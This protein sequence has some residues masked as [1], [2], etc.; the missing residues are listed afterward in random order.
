MKL[1][2]LSLLNFKNLI[3][4]IKKGISFICS[5]YSFLFVLSSLIS[6]F[7]S[8]LLMLSYFISLPLLLSLFSSFLPKEISLLSLLF[9]K[10]VFI[11]E[12]GSFSLYDCEFFKGI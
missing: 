1:S 10:F 6:L 7:N 9:N 5:L 8:I 12:S 2:F 4:N 11:S 3:G